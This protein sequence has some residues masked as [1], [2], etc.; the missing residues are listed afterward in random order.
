[1]LFSNQQYSIF[2]GPGWRNALQD[3]LKGLLITERVKQ[4]LLMLWKGHDLTGSRVTVTFAL[5]DVP[6]ALAATALGVQV[7]A[8]PA[9]PEPC[10]GV[11]CQSGQCWQS[12]ARAAAQ[13]CSPPGEHEAVLLPQG[14]RQGRWCEAIRLLLLLENQTVVQTIRKSF[15]FYTCFLSGLCQSVAPGNL[16]MVKEKCVFTVLKADLV[17]SFVM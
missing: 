15:H 3:E 1:M 17:G 4:D 12:R 11:W 6:A 9:E 8:V 13:L 2:S 16:L 10:W 14:C 5:G 7:G